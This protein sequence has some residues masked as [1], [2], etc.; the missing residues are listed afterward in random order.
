MKVL[1]VDDEP[2][3]RSLVRSALE[4]ARVPLEAIEA[5]NAE[6]ALKAVG[7]AQPDIMVLD[8]ALPGRERPRPLAE[9]QLDRAAHHGERAAEVVRHRREEVALHLIDGTQR[10]RLGGLLQERFTL[11]AQPAQLAE[12]SGHEER[13]KEIHGD[14]KF[15]GG[16]PHGGPRP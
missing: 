2:D 7:S 11:T 14:G 15:L 4:Y 9:E 6:E 3:V 13:R 8:L 1:I 12:E 10:F 16:V 5:E